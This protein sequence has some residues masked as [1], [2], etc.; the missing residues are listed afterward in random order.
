MGSAV[1]G[2]YFVMVVH[3]QLLCP[4]RCAEY[5]RNYGRAVWN[6][7]DSGAVEE[8]NLSGDGDRREHLLFAASDLCGADACIWG[9]GHRAFNRFCDDNFR[10]HFRAG[11]RYD[12]IFF[13]AV[14]SDLRYFVRIPLQ[15]ISGIRDVGVF[16]GG[17]LDHDVGD[18]C[19]KWADLLENFCFDMG[20]SFGFC[21]FISGIWNQKNAGFV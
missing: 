7:A 18:G 14:Y 13:S 9:G 12:H 3:L 2:S 20:S 4:N 16:A 17:F 11:G 10:H 5:Y 15:Q 1:F 19:F 21:G 6:S 8:Q